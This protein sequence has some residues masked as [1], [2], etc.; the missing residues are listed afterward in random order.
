MFS[1]YD[2]INSQSMCNDSR[3]KCLFCSSGISSEYFH[4]DIKSTDVIPLSDVYTRIF[5]WYQILWCN[6]T[7]IYYKYTMEFI[8]TGLV[9]FN[10]CMYVTSHWH[11]PQT[12]ISQIAPQVPWNSF[13]HSSHHKFSWSFLFTSFFTSLLT[14]FFAS[15][16]PSSCESSLVILLLSWFTI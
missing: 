4:I 8:N 9:L 3:C 10:Q 12:K 5:Y 15:M 6:E 7:C 13:L 2:N 11:S 16:V 14:S 1:R